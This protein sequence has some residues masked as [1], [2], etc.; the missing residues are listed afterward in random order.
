[1]TQHWEPLSRAEVASV[2]E[3][4][5]A[6]HRVPSVMH[7][8]THAEEFGSR[9][10]EV[11]GIL[12]RYPQ[13]VQIVGL[14]V[15]DVHR[16]LPEDPEY[17]W[18]NYDDNYNTGHIEP[19]ASKALDSVVA[20][21]DWSRLP[22]MLESFPNPQNP[23]AIGTNPPP[24]GRYRVGHWWFCLFERHWQLRGMENAL[25]DYYTSPDE[26]HT[27][28]QA[29]TSFYKGLMERGRREL[30]LDAVFTSDDLGT[31]TGPFFSL[32]M[33]EEFYAPYYAELIAHA[34]S[35]GMHFWLHACGCV[36]PMLPALVGMGLDVIHP[37]Q[38]Y[39]MD[40]RHIADRFGG[41]ICIWAGFDVQRI[42]PWGTPDEVRAEV[43]F[44]LDT[45]GRPDGRLIFGAGNG[46][47]GDCSIASL[48]ALF[49]ES[50]RYSTELAATG[51]QPPRKLA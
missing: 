43:R 51:W 44:M 6:A 35:L 20:I 3:G 28:F 48:E 41:D 18:V 37:I 42:I 23:R 38:K 31:Q 17:R 7:M 36:E 4:R 11:R 30:G 10:D 16:G 9:A 8:W 50:F 13:D 12:A 34:H 49:D 29:L 40:E 26:V 46:I 5:G 15:P 39:T 25:T 47:N 32:A 1:M 21:D 19:G 33:F 27:L 22:G 45:Y 14:R 2:I 24:D